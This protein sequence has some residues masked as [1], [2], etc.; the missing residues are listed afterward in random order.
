MVATTFIKFY[1]PEG[2]QCSTRSDPQW[3]DRLVEKWQHVACG[4][5]T[6]V[7]ASCVRHLSEIQDRFEKIGVP[8]GIVHGHMA[9]TVRT[10]IFDQLRRGKI[11]VLC[12]AYPFVELSTI[13][14]IEC[15]VLA[16]D[17]MSRRIYLHML[18][19]LTP[20]DEA[21]PSVVID[22]FGNVFKYG[23]PS[24]AHVAQ[25]ETT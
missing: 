2:G 7:I 1:A 13:Y 15:I 23:M 9:N 11:R 25:D 12:T 5:M 6:V 17:V 16:S 8:A 10:S 14:D 4:R 20:P 19:I 18:D 21:S 3:M 24:D 22:I